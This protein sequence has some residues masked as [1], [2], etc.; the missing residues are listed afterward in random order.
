M[1]EQCLQVCVR[2]ESVSARY[3]GRVASV[4][5]SR[6]PLGLPLRLE[7]FSIFKPTCVDKGFFGKKCAESKSAQPEWALYGK[8]NL[9]AH[10]TRKKH[11]VTAL[12]ARKK[13]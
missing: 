13:S 4:A 6:A 1:Y 3:I 5:L 8:K 11:L 9:P 10:F 7:D 12:F 2:E